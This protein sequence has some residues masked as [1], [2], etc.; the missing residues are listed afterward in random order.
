MPKSKIEKEFQADE[1]GTVLVPKEIVAIPETVV[2]K[3][4]KREISEKQRANMEKMIAANKE[5]WAK[6]REERARA[7]EEERA[8]RMEEEKKLIEAGTHVRV[9]VTKKQYKPR[10]RKDSPPAPLKLV[11]QNGRYEEPSDTDRE[12]G[13]YNRRYTPSDT[14]EPTETEVSDTEVT[15]SEYEEERPKARRARREMK[16]T[17]RVVEKVDAVLNQ[18][19]NPYL[20]ML[21][22]R[23]R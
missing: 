1:E 9:K 6:L 22:S 17:L 8:K 18:V 4:V 5:R 15:E 16:K 19:Q 12:R 11:R 20:S 23:W 13:S 14:E 21:S 10:E 2:K 3:T 7:A